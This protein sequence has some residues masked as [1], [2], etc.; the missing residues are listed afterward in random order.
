MEK[1]ICTDHAERIA[2]VEV[3]VENMKSAQ[4]VLFGKIEAAGVKNEAALKDLCAEVKKLNFRVAGLNGKV[5]EK[6]VEVEHVLDR[7]PVG[8]LNEALKRVFKSPFFWV[9]LG[10]MILKIFVFGEYPSFSQR[11][12]PYMEPVTS[13]MQ[14]M[15]EQHKALHEAGIP[16]LHDE[17]G[18]PVLVGNGNGAVPKGGR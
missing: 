8:W 12:R 15:T 5:P 14:A 4:T 10:W 11:T 9:L 2:A 16:H 6:D 3:E 1:N 17:S 7:E 13:Q 18:K